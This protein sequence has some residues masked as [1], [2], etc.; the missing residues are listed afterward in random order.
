MAQTKDSM[1][2]FTFRRPVDPSEPQEIIDAKLRDAF[3]VEASR[4][5]AKYF[6][7]EKREDIIGK[8]LLKLFKGTIPAWFVDYG[9][10]VEDRS[11]EDIERV[12]QIPV[13]NRLRPMRIYMQ[14]IFEGDKL[15]SQWVTI[16]DIS[17]EEEHKRVIEENERLKVLA[18]QAVGLRTFALKFE[19]HDAAHPH[20]II[21]V[22]EKERG[23]WWE[24]VHVQDRVA[25]EEAFAAFYNGKTEQLH[26]LFR[27]STEDA[28]Q[29]WMESWAVASGRDAEGKPLG[30]VGVIMDR[31]QS[32]Q[33]ESRLIASQ[34]L[35]SLGVM[36]GGIAHD[37]NNLLMSITGSLDLIIA[38]HPH[39]SKELGI[40]EDAAKQAAQLCDQLLTYAGRGSAELKSLNLSSVVESSR[41]LLSMNKHHKANLSFDIGE[42]CWVKGDS[43]Q[44]TQ[45]VMNL[46]KNA[47]DALEGEAGSIDVKVAA[48]DYDPAWRHEYQL[49]AD[50]TPGRYVRVEV[51]DTGNGI[52]DADVSQLFDPFYT[53]KFTGRGLGLAV[54]MGVVRGHGGAIRVSSRL[55]VGTTMQVL[56]PADDHEAEAQPVPADTPRHMLSGCVLVVDDES[57]VRS[58]AERLLGSIGLDA[59]LADGGERAI[60]LV[61]QSPDRFDA[62]LLDV[63]MPGIDGVETASRI[64]AAHPA[65]PIVLCS[66]YS[67]VAVP[68]LLSD[69]VE[70]LQKP[71]RLE[72]LRSALEPLVAQGK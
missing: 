42:D 27:A 22:G 7:F 11:F 54:V 49:G 28:D 57:S 50:L 30:I 55:G 6:G 40:M 5:F 48:V 62:V 64:L 44:L 43:G 61:N 34:R 47:S 51:S 32:K 8:H 19:A 18:L 16:R 29:A 12:V 65:T 20:G 4:S 45:V 66:G 15:V 72:D 60:D 39:L 2:C 24:H 36:A 63:S 35:E 17:E 21:V 1:V 52:P 26:T 31:T 56:L 10:E 68:S 37:F 67:A 59:V 46:V 71:Y 14:N 38:K 13:G 33:L 41:E 70:F 53:T 3:V 69:S 25:L 58:I 23:D 9:Q